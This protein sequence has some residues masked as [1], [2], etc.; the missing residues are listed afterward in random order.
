MNK[1]S[2]N[3][4]GLSVV[5]AVHNEEKNLAQCLDSVKD[6]LDELI[7][8]DGESTDN[9]LQIA[10]TYG[11]KII[12][13][14]NKLNFHINKQ[15]GNDKAKHELV[16]QLD[17]DEALDEELKQ[18][19]DSMKMV[20]RL[21]AQAWNIKRKNYFMGTWMRKGGQYPDPVI[22]LFVKGKARLP[23]KNVHEQMEVD[24]TVAWAEGHILHYSNP[25]FATY[26]Q[27]FNTYTTFAANALKN[28]NLSL[29]LMTMLNYFVV[30]PVV[31]FLSLYIRHKG[32]LDGW[33]GF[34]F[35]LMSAVQL[36]VTYLKLWELYERK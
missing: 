31:I 25:D 7:I 34:V 36:P 8:V 1:G 13:T 21:P 10:K 17:A 18:F 24:G 14:T 2:K 33:V 9:T 26:M 3:I 30:K 11:A 32:I 22:R 29:G 16:L 23:Q 6:I 27:K 35:A 15:M 20:E 12:E 5:L 28:E 4:R 19:I